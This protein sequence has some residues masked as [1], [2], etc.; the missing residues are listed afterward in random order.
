[1]K[2]HAMKRRANKIPCFLQL[3]FLHA[4]KTIKEDLFDLSVQLSIKNLFDKTLLMTWQINTLHTRHLSKQ[5]LQTLF[6][7]GRIWAGWVFPRASC[8][9]P[10]SALSSWHR[11]TAAPSRGPKWFPHI[12]TDI[13]LDDTLIHPRDIAYTRPYFGIFF[14]GRG[15]SINLLRHF[16]QPKTFG[17]CMAPEK[18]EGEK[19]LRK[20]I[21][22]SFFGMHKSVQI[23]G[24]W[25]KLMLWLFLQRCRRNMKLISYELGIQSGGMTIGK[26][27]F[28]YLFYGELCV[29]KFFFFTC[30]PLSF[31]PSKKYF[32]KNCLSFLPS[33]SIADEG[34]W[35][36]S[37]P[38]FSESVSTTCEKTQKMLLFLLWISIHFRVEFQE[39]KVAQFG[40]AKPGTFHRFSETNVNLFK[41]VSAFF[42]PVSPDPQLCCKGKPFCTLHGAIKGRERQFSPPHSSWKNPAMRLS[43]CMKEEKNPRSP[44]SPPSTKACISWRQQAKFFL[45]PPISLLFLLCMENWPRMARLR[46]WGEKVFPRFPL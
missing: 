11:R 33:L 32:L 8:A 37:L 18:T 40:K 7:P 9:W 16:R 5:W 19:K 31:C 20:V 43:W 17:F 41:S 38:S 44:P 2:L 36:L 24:N 29:F 25:R 12:I 6:L 15:H 27:P 13:P 21:F 1:M 28:F 26:Y 39:H 42:S 30:V 14:V 3:F 35:P 45:L 34:D 23:C 10:G 46:L 22:F 4:W